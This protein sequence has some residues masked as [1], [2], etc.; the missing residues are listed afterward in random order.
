MAKSGHMVVLIKSQGGGSGTG[1][2]PTAT[3]PAQLS[4]APP[5]PPSVK[6]T[7]PPPV[8]PPVPL[9]TSPPPSGP[10][11]TQWPDDTVLNI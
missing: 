9:P 6:T 10:R 7:V 1:G 3:S 5:V 4:V 2:R 11:K 8:P